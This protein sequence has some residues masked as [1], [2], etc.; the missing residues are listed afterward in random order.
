MDEYNIPFAKRFINAVVFPYRCLFKFRGFGSFIM[1]M[2]EER[3]RRVAKYCIGTVLDIGCGPNNRFIRNVYPNGL[4]ID[5]YPYEGVELVY[6]DPTHLAFDDNSFDTVTLIAVGG[7]IPKHMRRQEFREF[8]RV[9]RHGGRLVM[10]EG[11][12]ITQYLHH[13]WVHFLDTYFGTDIDVDSERGMVEGEEYAMPHREI[14]QLL[15]E[16]GLTHVRTER[17]QWG[18]NKVYVAENL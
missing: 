11:E 4:G 18:L 5:F 15:A 14:L 3:M 9:L 7:H 17:F 12:P 16:S 13:K 8:T 1:S 10:T 6:S 2:E